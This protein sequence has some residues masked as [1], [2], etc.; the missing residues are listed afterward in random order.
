MLAQDANRLLQVILRPGGDA[1]LIGL[2]RC[3]HLLELAVLEELD[4]LARRLD[5]DALL[6]RDDAARP[7]RWRRARSSP[8]V[9][10][11]VGTPRRTSRPCRISQSAVILNSSSAVST[12]VLSVRLSSIAARDP[13][14]S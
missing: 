14:K 8:G 9:R 6:E 3:L 2:D 10:F 4:D 11:L 7:C 13:L 5:R 12:S 1:D